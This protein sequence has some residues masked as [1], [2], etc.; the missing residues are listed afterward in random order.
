MFFNYV[1]IFIFNLWGKSSLCTKF[2]S[3]FALE[4][5]AHGDWPPP[6]CLKFF[7]FVLEVNQN[8]E[9]LFLIEV[10]H[11]NFFYLCFNGAMFYLA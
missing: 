8:F 2:L 10:T 4:H 7:E 1:F 5:M 3:L 9:H 11:P 6:R